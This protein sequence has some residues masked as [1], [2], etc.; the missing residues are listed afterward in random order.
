MQKKNSNVFGRL[1]FSWEIR[2]EKN[3]GRSKH[4]WIKFAV[5]ARRTAKNRRHSQK[6]VFF[7]L[8]LVLKANAMLGLVTKNT[9][10]STLNLMV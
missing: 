3:Y 1:I 6:F 2:T 9:Q 4:F 8:T 5:L 7:A 10:N